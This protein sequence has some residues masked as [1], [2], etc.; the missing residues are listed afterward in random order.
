MRCVKSILGLVVL[1]L[2]PAAVFGQSTETLIQENETVIG[3]GGMQNLSN[4]AVNDSKTWM[5]L[6]STTFADATRD[7]CILSNGFV[8]MR[9][10]TQLISPA[11]SILDEWASLSLNDRGDVG[12]VIQTKPVTGPVV[13]GAYWNLVMVAIKDQVIVSPLLGV[14]ADWDTF[15]VAKL[16]D[17]NQ[18]FIIGEVANPAVTRSRERTLVRYDLDDLGN[19]LATTVLATEGMTVPAGLQLSGSAC[20]GNND[21]VFAA[22]DR[23]D[24]IAYIAQDTTQALVINME[25]IVAQTGQP[26][27]VG[28]N[29][30][31]LTLARVAINNSG[32]YVIA[33]SVGNASDLDGYL[34]VKNGQKFARSNE[35]LPEVGTVGNGT[36][37]PLYIANTGDVYWHV[38][39]SNGDAFMRNLEV[40]VQSGRTVV[41]NRL[42]T[43]V[44]GALNAFATSSN[45]RFFVGNVQLQTIGQAAVFADFGLVLELPG[46]RGNLG[47]L[48]LASG[49][50]LVGGEFQLAMDEGQAP[51]AAA[52]LFFSKRAF[53]S[54]AGCGVNL[55]GFGELFLAPP[56][57][58][59]RALP[60]WDGT[61]PSLTTLRIPNKMALVDAVFFAQGLFFSPG[62]PT[63]RFRLTNGLRIEL[64]AP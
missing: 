9:E 20:L 64:G 21:H 44:N 3:L 15:Q 34:I 27:P 41:E 55:E 30:R 51:G 7:G 14:G 62:H 56:L 35:V 58:G 17:N 19:I 1:G 42:V 54:P 2:S 4:V 50:A 47:E 49:M 31:V 63:E 37:A 57:G 26:S 59:D 29:W 46:C 38:R 33:G 22:N 6:L 13:D 39:G 23:G 43:T 16:N 10:G 25:T 40:I 12:M 60:F 36:Q 48:S 18:L 8:S 61:N 53:Q 5:T 24:T 11:G 52:T 32:E 28:A 45:G